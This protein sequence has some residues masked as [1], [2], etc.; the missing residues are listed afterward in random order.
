MHF[1]PGCNCGIWIFDSTMKTRRCGN[2]GH[3]CPTAD[4]ALTAD[5]EDPDWKSM[6]DKLVHQWFWGVQ[7]L[8]RTN[9][10]NPVQLI[11]R[12]RAMMLSIAVLLGGLIC[13]WGVE[14]F[15]AG[16]GRG[17]RLVVLHG[18]EF[19]GSFRADEKRCRVRDVD[20]RPGDGAMP[21]RGESWTLKPSAG[22]PSPALSR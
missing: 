11:T 16:G 20:V 1:L 6:P 10:N 8:Y 3:R 19:S 18:S 7:T 5:F 21:G 22:W 9:G 2:T 12:C 15:R 17:C 14:N 13:Y 4:H